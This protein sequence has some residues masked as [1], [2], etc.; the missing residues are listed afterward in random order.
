[1]VRKEVE[2]LFEWPELLSQRLW[3]KFATGLDCH[4]ETES[5]RKHILEHA[6]FVFRVPTG[7]ICKEFVFGRNLCL[8][9]QVVKSLSH[10]VLT[11]SLVLY[12]SG[13]GC[14]PEVKVTD[15]LLEASI[16]ISCL[17]ESG[18]DLVPLALTGLLHDSTDK[19]RVVAF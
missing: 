13:V 8:A 15:R 17:V 14:P 12:L 10:Q 16:L 11:Q 6:N 4:V 2:N 7:Y 19:P 18:R 1:M 3:A 9:F 5:E